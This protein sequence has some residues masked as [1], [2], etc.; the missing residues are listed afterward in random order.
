MRDSDSGIKEPS[1]SSLMGVMTG[2]K[3]ALRAGAAATSASGTGV[4]GAGTGA[5]AD[6]YRDRTPKSV[7]TGTIR[8]SMEEKESKARG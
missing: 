5:G 1:G 3:K 8:N 6:T 4:T 7:E 2:E